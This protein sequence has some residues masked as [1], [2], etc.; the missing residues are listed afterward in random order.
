MRTCIVICLLAVTGLAAGCGSQTETN[1]YE[2]DT[3][4][5]FS[6]LE[7]TAELICRE[8]RENGEREVN[9]HHIDPLLR[10]QYDDFASQYNSRA[11]RSRPEN[12]P[13]RAPSIIHI[14]DKF[15]P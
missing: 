14:D 9:V 1:L 10:G 4:T 5:A 12:L 6:M 8:S 15:C 2:R 3:Q 11:D 13:K 7:R